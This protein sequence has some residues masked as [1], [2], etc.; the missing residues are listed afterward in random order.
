MPD[1]KDTQFTSMVRLAAGRMQEGFNVFVIVGIPL[2]GSSG[3]V[4]HRQG[5][6]EKCKYLAAFA[7]DVINEQSED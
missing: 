1:E 5:P 3:P 2:D 6:R 4:V 7:H